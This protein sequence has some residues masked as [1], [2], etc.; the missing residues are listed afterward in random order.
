MKITYF[1]EKMKLN[2]SNHSLVSILC[3]FNC[4]IAE[5]AD[6]GKKFFHP[7]LNSKNSPQTLN[8]K[9]SHHILQEERLRW[10]ED[11]LKIQW[12]PKLSQCYWFFRCL[13]SIT[14]WLKYLLVIFSIKLLENVFF[15]SWKFGAENFSYWVFT[16]LENIM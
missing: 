1:L 2:K 14:V 8:K 7:L 3:I 12:R 10:G 5:S 16:A 6:S 13:R 9:N 4:Q 15:I 11:L